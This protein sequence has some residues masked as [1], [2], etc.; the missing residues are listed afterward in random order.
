MTISSSGTAATQST[1]CIWR[2]CADRF[3]SPVSVAW[4]RSPVTRCSPLR[5]EKK[6]LPGI[7]FHFDQAFKRSF[8]YGHNL[9]LCTRGCSQ[10]GSQ[11]CFQLVGPCG[12]PRIL[13]TSKRGESCCK[14]GNSKHRSK[15]SDHGVKSSNGRFEVAKVTQSAFAGPMKKGDT[16]AASLSSCRLTM[17]PVA[18]TNQLGFLSSFSVIRAALPDRSRR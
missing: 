8:G 11:L 4:K 16:H 14:P 10:G 5:S 13:R 15:C 17:P 6:L 18:A 7:Q 2:A 12:R 3:T 1:I 9:Q